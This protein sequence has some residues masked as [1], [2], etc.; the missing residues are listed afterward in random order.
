MQNI[1]IGYVLLIIIILALVM[2]ADGLRIAYPIV[3]VLG[4][5]AFSFT[6]AFSR[7]TIDPQIVFFIFLPPL[8]YEAAWQVS[9][10]ELWKWRRVI[11]ILLY[12]SL[13]T[14]V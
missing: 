9:W 4:G 11:T 2:L 5:L 3:L 12:N 7:I 10:K 8:L 6:S 14:S 1:F 13:Q